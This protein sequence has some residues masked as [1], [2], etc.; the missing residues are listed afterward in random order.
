M[1]W[2]AVVPDFSTSG[3]SDAPQLAD[4]QKTLSQTFPSGAKEVIFLVDFAMTPPNGTKIGVAVVCKNGP[5]EFPEFNTIMSATKGVETRVVL[6]RRPKSGAFPDGPCQGTLSL[7]EQAV[8][9]L[10]WTIGK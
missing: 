3:V 5:V 4:R 7:N 8:A 2:I 10:N 1:L 9:R 6:S